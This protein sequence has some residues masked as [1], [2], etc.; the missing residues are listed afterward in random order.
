MSTCWTN[1]MRKPN[2]LASIVVSVFGTDKIEQLKHVV[3]APMAFF[4]LSVVCAGRGSSPQ[5][6]HYTGEL[7]E[8][9]PECEKTVP[10]RDKQQ[11][12]AAATNTDKLTA[13]WTPAYRGASAGDRTCRARHFWTTRLR[14]PKRLCPRWCS[15]CGYISRSQTR[16]QMSW[17]PPATTSGT[18]CIFET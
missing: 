18:A 17:T 13:V 6:N 3:G 1:S 2:T 12:L 11:D 5:V 9:A 10:L 4:N 7:M 8:P 15:S 16:T 14:P